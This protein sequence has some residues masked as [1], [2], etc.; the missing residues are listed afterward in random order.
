MKGAY[1]DKEL[2]VKQGKFEWYSEE[3]RLK[4]T[5][6]YEYGNKTGDWITYWK[7]GNVCI[8]DRYAKKGNIHQQESFDES[9]HLTA[10]ETFNGDRR[11]EWL[12]YNADGTTHKDTALANRSA[13]F[14]GRENALFTFLST[15]I[16]YPETAQKSSNEGKVYVH[17]IIGKDGKITD[18]YVV[19]SPDS[20]LSTEAVRVIRLMPKWRPGI[21][22][23]RVVFTPYTLPILFKLE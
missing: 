19:K 20:D 16:H 12:Y 5:G 3:G 11:I 23:N 10:R 15:H 1:L 4:T 17:F 21:A 7:E 13:E 14:P 6:T 2:T 9:G 18:T 8:R 22:A